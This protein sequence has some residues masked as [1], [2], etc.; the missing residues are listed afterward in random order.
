ML[1]WNKKHEY[2]KNENSKFKYHSLLYD[3]DGCP[4]ETTTLN[5]D[6][7]SHLYSWPDA[8]IGTTLFQPC[9]CEDIV[10]SQSGNTSRQCAGTYSNGGSWGQADYTQCAILSS[11]VTRHLCA[12]AMVCLS[13]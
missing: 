1:L 12:S 6:D 7:I 2:I 4:S 13:G 9:P 5:T 3:T 10:G 8:E 11:E